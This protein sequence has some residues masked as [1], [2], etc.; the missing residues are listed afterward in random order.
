[1]D[2]RPSVKVDESDFNGQLDNLDYRGQTVS[3][4]AVTLAGPRSMSYHTHS[5]S[6][7]QQQLPVLGQNTGFTVDG[8]HQTSEDDFNAASRLYDMHMV[9]Q[10]NTSSSLHFNDA[11]GAGSWG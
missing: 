5:N 9:S 6:H 1:M 4:P 11:T 3:N 10:N 8:T 2:S 7:S